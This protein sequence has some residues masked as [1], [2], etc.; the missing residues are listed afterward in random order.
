M[1]PVPSLDLAELYE[2]ARAMRDDGS[3]TALIAKILKLTPER[4]AQI[5]ERLDSGDQRKPG[6]RGRA[7]A[8]VVPPQA[9]P[10]P[11]LRPV[12]TEP[13]APVETPTSGRKSAQCGT[14]SGYQRHYSRGEKPCQPCK[15]ATNERSRARAAAKR[16][17]AT[18]PTPAA[19]AQTPAHA[20]TT[21]VQIRWLVPHGVHPDPGMCFEY[22]VVHRGGSVVRVSEA[23][24]EVCA[25]AGDKVLR[26]QV[27]GWLEVTP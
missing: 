12:P 1:T 25:Q 16:A 9:T 10:P 2:R 20:A 11:V 22:G 4:A 23:S 17:E 3:D 5:V 7:R 6:S 14:V 8:R 13:V 21:T 15:D 19:P 18:V 27:S 26:R 24:A